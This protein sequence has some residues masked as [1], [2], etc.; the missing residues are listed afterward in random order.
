[1][2]LCSIIVTCYNKGRVIAHAIESALAQTFRGIEVIVVDDGSTDSSPEILKCYRDKVRLIRKENGGQASAIN[3]GFK[4]SRGDIVFFLDGDDLLD[5]DTVER[6][7][8][9]WNQKVSKI[10]FRLRVIDANGVFVG[11]FL[12][13]YRPLLKPD[14]NDSVFCRFGFYPTPPGSGNAFSRWYLEA[15]MPLPEPEFRSHGELLLLGTAPVFGLVL[16]LDGVAGSWR[17]DGYNNESTSGGLDKA[18]TLLRCGNSFIELAR[19]RSLAASRRD[20]L[21]SA[22]LVPRWPTHLK[23]QLIVTKFRPASDLAVRKIWTAAFMYLKTIILWPEYTWRHRLLFTVWSV[24][25]V[26]LPRFAL[27]RIPGIIRPLTPD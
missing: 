26:A 14:V 9:I 12:P 18:E 17:R 27:R 23:N 10:H 19:K 2:S 6:V 11:T 4:S 7:V 8:A 25:M 13:P 20:P 5:P 24:V 3:V 1:V 22:D 16:P 15:V 21:L